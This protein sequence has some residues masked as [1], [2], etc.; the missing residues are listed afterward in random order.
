MIKSKQEIINETVGYYSE[1][2]TRRAIYTDKHGFTDCRYLT[3]DGKMC[4]VGRCLSTPPKGDFGDVYELDTKIDLEKS[5]KPE[6]RGH[7]LEF[8]YTLQAIHDTAQS[9]DNT[10]LTNQGRALVRSTE[11]KWIND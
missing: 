2:P 4:A 9:W 8:W 10:G 1:D 6:Y 11:E 5:L 7:A 3:D